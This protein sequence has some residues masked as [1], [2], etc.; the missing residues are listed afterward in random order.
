MSSAVCWPYFDSPSIFA[1]I[2]DKDIGGHFMIQP[3]VDHCHSKQQY[4][5]NSAIIQTKWLADEGVCTITDFMPRPASTS[6]SDKPLLPWLIR[7]VEIQRGTLPFRLECF[8]GFDYAR[9]EHETTVVDDDQASKANDGK[10]R[11][12]A[13]FKSK[14][15]TM[16]LRCVTGTNPELGLCEQDAITGVDFEI[17]SKTWPR[18]KGPGISATFTLTEGQTV[19]FVFREDPHTADDVPAVPDNKSFISTK[20]PLQ[21]RNPGEASLKLKMF[22]ATAFDPL[23]NSALIQTIQEAVSTSFRFGSIR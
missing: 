12:K 11:K 8:P 13:V 10:T 20:A 21:A 19:D 1:R 18:H 7:R 5:P 9:A 16:E 15:M 17:D 23:L 22:S 14:D 3:A 2:L 4:L 6:R